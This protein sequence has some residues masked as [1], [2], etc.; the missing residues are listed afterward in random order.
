MKENSFG[1]CSFTK[2]LPLSRNQSTITKSTRGIRGFYKNTRTL[3]IKIKVE[4]RDYKLLRIKIS[5]LKAI[6]AKEK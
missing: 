2:I 6:S 5:V 1:C 3:C 4:E